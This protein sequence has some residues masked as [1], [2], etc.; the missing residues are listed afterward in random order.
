VEDGW[1]VAVAFVPM[2]PRQSPNLRRPSLEPYYRSMVVAFGSVRRWNPDI[3]Q[4]LVTTEPPPQPYADA[5]A[6]LGV[7]QLTVPF[8]HRPPD[9]FTA[10][11]AAST[12]QLDALAATSGR[13]LFLDPDVVCLGALDDLLH[14]VPDGSAGALA[15]DYPPDH[16]VNGLS[17]SQAE[18]I[19]RDLGE[20]AGVP[21]HYGGECYAVSAGAREP[22]LTRADTAWADSLDRWRDGR[23]YL[24]TEE[25]LLSYALRGVEVVELDAHIQRI[26]TAARHRT[27]S[28]REGT[29][30][31]WHL[32]S[33]KD[34]GFETVFPAVVDADSWFWRDT[35]TAWWRRIARSFGVRHRTPTRLLRDTAGRTLN[36]IEGVRGRARS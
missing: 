20:P 26:W 12:Y 5:L 14:D 1:R 4:T 9:G 25:H 33:E 24:V 30:T 19:H 15:I 3:G 22:L 28:G 32:P 34:Q 7:R 18:S 21:V 29:L 35:P 17:R 6:S 36:V 11:F 13:T 8:A 27:V 23:P 31:L 10:R 2:D 16:D